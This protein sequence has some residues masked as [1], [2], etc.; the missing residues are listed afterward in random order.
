MS[1]GKFVMTHAKSF[2]GLTT[3]NHLGQIWHQ[4][5]QMATKITTQLLQQ[6]GMKNIDSMLSMFPVKY[7]ESDD[8]F[9]WKLAGSSERN[10]RLVETIFEGSVVTDDSVGVGAGRLPFQMVFE[11]PYFT[12]VMQIAGEHPDTYRVIL[13]SDARPDGTNRFVYDA[14][15]FGGEESLSGIPG[16]ELASGTRW[17]IEGA[18][19]EDELSIKGA[20]IQ[21]NTP[22]TMRNSFSYIRM[23]HKV[24]GK[25]I[26]TKLTGTMAVSASIDTRDSKTGKI[27]SSNTWMQEVYWQFEQALAK[28]KSRTVFFGKTNRDENGKYLNSGKSSLKIKAGSGIRE[29]MEVSN[30]SFYN[31]FSL[32]LLTDM[33]SELSE[34]KLDFGERK[35]VIK[36]GERGAIQFHEAVTKEAMGWTSVGF[37]N[38]NVNVINKTS[39][40]LHDNSLSGGFQFTEWKAPN[41]VTVTID[42]DPFYDDKVRNKVL[43]PNGGVAE[44]YRY[45]IFYIG[46][47]QEPNIQKCMIKGEDE[48]RG[49]IGGIRDPFTGRRGGTMNRMEDSATMTAMCTLGS[50]V[51]DPSRTASL[52][53]NILG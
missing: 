45:D 5:P 8:D 21:F 17:S 23:E 47:T 10:I 13:T 33:L 2:S 49:Y 35:F 41:G 16:T 1:V 25:M 24:S 40:K 14:E 37:D 43:H 4:A 50:M 20:G 26:D 32:R 48:L 29:Q 12:D 3:R 39:S 15:V 9:I 31:L 7:F 19:I 53:P 46:S 28:I 34:G 36:T 30:T 38:T 18:P 51:L 42:V 52:L 22:Y 27:H 11:E 6:S 44:S